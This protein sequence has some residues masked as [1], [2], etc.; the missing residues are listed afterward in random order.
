MKLLVVVLNQPE[1]LNALLELLAEAGVEGATVLDSR[2]MG[3]V[4]SQE[5]PLL[6]RFGH[7]LTEV[8]PL[9]HTVFSVFERSADAQAVLEALRADLPASC[10]VAFLLDVEGFVRLRPL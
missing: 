9:N 6:A 8:H 5:E 3:R 7:L 2:G 1:R 10:G 4:L